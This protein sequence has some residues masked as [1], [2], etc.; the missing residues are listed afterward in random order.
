MDNIQILDDELKEI[1]GGKLST[2]AKIAIIVSSIIVIVAGTT[3]CIYLNHLGN[4][5][6]NM[7]IT[8][9]NIMCRLSIIYRKIVE[10]DG[11]L[12]CLDFKE[13]RDITAEIDN[14]EHQI[15][16]IG[17]NHH[18][19]SNV[20]RH[21]RFILSQHEIRE[22][23]DKLDIYND[24]ASRY[25]HQSEMYKD[26]AAR[27]RPLSAGYRRHAAAYFNGLA[28]KNP[29]SRH[30]ESMYLLRDICGSITDDE[31]NER[32]QSCIKNCTIEQSSLRLLVDT[33]WDFRA[34]E[35]STFSK[36]NENRGQEMERYFFNKEYMSMMPH[37][38]Y[39][40][41]QHEYIRLIGKNNII[42]GTKFLVERHRHC[43]DTFNPISLFQT[44]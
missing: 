2:K 7:L 16:A 27:H 8:E 17:P 43:N 38:Y 37:N 19:G 14:I 13:N 39:R 3:L 4:I 15:N 6:K 41:V 20:L 42:L 22:N 12:K 25:Q 29:S 11:K 21:L 36:W 1:T 24:E 34:D 33:Y 26:Y 31:Y 10:Q 44:S 5:A 40:D 23:Q 32:M 28:K 9:C 35:E 18:R 30:L